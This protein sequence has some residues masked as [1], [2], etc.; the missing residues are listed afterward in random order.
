ME[1][2]YFDVFL[3]SILND[4]SS[5]K[6]SLFFVEPTYHTGWSGFVEYTTSIT[7][8]LDGSTY[9]RRPLCRGSV[10]EVLFVQ[11]V[12][13][14]LRID[15]PKFHNNIVQQFLPGAKWSRTRHSTGTLYELNVGQRRVPETRREM[16]RNLQE[17]IWE[18]TTKLHWLRLICMKCI[19][20]TCTRT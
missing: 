4:S 19:E 7:N 10:R 13:I 8:D 18:D 6:F 2:E 20:G 1:K 12:N 16:L 14:R 11:L 3:E 9:S 5:K 15:F 17:R